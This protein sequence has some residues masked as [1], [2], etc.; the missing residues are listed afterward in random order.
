MKK[1][2]TK[3]FD[4]INVVGMAYRKTW[5]ER[6][7][8]LRMAV[9][10]FLVKLACFTV[11]ATYFE[12]Q[13]LYVTGIVLLPSFIVEGW[14]LA[15]WARTIMTGG[16]HRWPF[17]FSGDDN[18]DRAELLSRGRGI[19]AGMVAFALIN[20]LIVGYTATLFSGMP[21]IIAEDFDPQNPG[22]RVAIVG[23]IFMVTAYLL[24]RFMWVHIPLSLNI[25]LDK[26][27]E[28]LKQSDLTFPMVAIW[29]ICVIPAFLLI[30]MF[31]E[32]LVGVSGE[33]TPITQTLFG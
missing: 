20:F 33:A 6:T 19:M 32:L 2:N 1:N 13:S 5:E 8:L 21:N 17:R 29:M 12:D 11:L 28:T 27:F 26:I 15:H 4:I 30:Q 22:S 3:K 7:Y 25:S 14:F 16:A 23:I 31:G 10:P 18:K 9:I 24:F